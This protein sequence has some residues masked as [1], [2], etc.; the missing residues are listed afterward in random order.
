MPEKLE[1]AALPSLSRGG[2]VGACAP[3]GN[4]TGSSLEAFST[5]EGWAT[6]KATEAPASNTAEP[7]A[8]ISTVIAQK[9]INENH[10]RCCFLIVPPSMALSGC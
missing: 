8:T 3:A 4:T 5:G 2:A 9:V 10:E 1:G 7:S 6:A